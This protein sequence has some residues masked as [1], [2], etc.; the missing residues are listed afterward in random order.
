MLSWFYEGST[1]VMQGFCALQILRGFQFK[2]YTS[3]ELLGPFSGCW[4]SGMVGAVRERE[5]RAPRL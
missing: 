3:W 5:T 2:V 1:E 4:G